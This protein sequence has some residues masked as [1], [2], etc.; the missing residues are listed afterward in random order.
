VRETWFLSFSALAEQTERKTV[1][2]SCH[3]SRFTPCQPLELQKNHVRGERGVSEFI[4]DH[5][6]APLA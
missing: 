1:M 4:E 3:A 6:A 5:A 2:P